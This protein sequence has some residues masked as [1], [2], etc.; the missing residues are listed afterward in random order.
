MLF[1]S[2]LLKLEQQ[3]QKESD[4]GF[5]AS[6]KNKE[7]IAKA[8]ADEGNR[9]LREA[10]EDKKAQAKIASN[11]AIKIAEEEADAKFAIYKKS[12]ND[13]SALM[14]ANL[15]SIPAKQDQNMLA[16]KFMGGDEIAVNE[17]IILSY[18]EKAQAIIAANLA[19]GK[20]EAELTA[21]IREQSE[22]AALN[23]K[24]MTETGFS[25]AQ[26]ARMT[27]VKGEIKSVNTELKGVKTTSEGI[28]KSFGA[29]MI[30]SMIIG[31]LNEASGAFQKFGEDVLKVSQSTGMAFKESSQ[32]VYIAQRTHVGVEL[33]DRSMLLMTRA[34][35][36]HTSAFRAFNVTVK[37]SNG[38]YLSAIDILKNV[39][40]KYKELGGG[41]SG[42]AM[43]HNVLGRSGQL[44]VPIL[45]QG[46]DA[47]QKMQDQTKLLGLEMSKLETQR[48]QKLKKATTDMSMAFEGLGVQVAEAA[49]P[50]QTAL[51]NGLTNLIIA[52]DKLDPKLKESIEILTI[53]A[54]SVLFVVTSYRMFSMITDTDVLA[55]LAKLIPRL[56]LMGEVIVADALA[57]TARMIPAIL[58]LVAKLNV[59]LA[60]ALANTLNELKLLGA[61]FALTGGSIVV[62][63]AAGAAFGG[64]LIVISNNA[65]H[66][67]EILSDLGSVIANV[68]NPPGRKSALQVLRKDSTDALDEIGKAAEKTYKSVTKTF[69]DM[70]KAPNLAGDIKTGEDK[71]GQYVDTSAKKPPKKNAN[72]FHDDY[73]RTQAAFDAKV[74]LLETGTKEKAGIILTNQEKLALYNEYFAT[75][76]SKHKDYWKKHEK[77]EQSYHNRRKALSEAAIKEQSELAIKEQSE[78]ATLK[79]EEEVISGK[80]TQS[81]IYADQVI[82]DKLILEEIKKHY[83]AKS[84][85]YERQ[86]KKVIES[87]KKASDYELEQIHKIAQAKAELLSDEASGKA[88]TTK[89][90]V[91]N[92]L[93]F[94]KITP[95]QAI[96]ADI[97]AEKLKGV[98]IRAAHAVALAGLNELDKNYAADLAKLERDTLNKTRANDLEILKL[99]HK[100][101]QEQYK[102]LM[103]F[104]SAIK[105]SFAPAISGMLQGTLTLQSGMKQIFGSIGKAFADMVANM[106]TKWVS[107]MFTMNTATVIW[108]MITKLA[109]GDFQLS[110]LKSSLSNIHLIGTHTAAAVAASGQAKATG[111]VA[112]VEASV[113]TA[114][115]ALA[116]A[117]TTTAASLTTVATAAPIAA[118]GLGSMG[119]AMGLLTPLATAFVPTGVAI[120]ASSTAIAAPTVT[121]ALAMGHLAVAMAAASVAWIPVI[122]AALAPIAALATGAAIAMGGTLASFAVGAESL[123]ND[124]IANVH[125]GERILTNSENSKFTN[126]IN[127]QTNSNSNQPPVV[128]NHNY[129]FIDKRGVQEFFREH[130]DDLQRASA[131][132]ARLGN[133]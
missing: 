60:L 15:S 85:E 70:F 88:N 20:S 39:A 22:A 84:V 11:E 27:A 26:I 2:A 44:L 36:A 87:T 126:F 3:Q 81:E 23:A 45:M 115:T 38:T 31:K 34:A 55:S 101:Y 18:E 72:M 129:S 80:K 105:S 13:A 43:A 69:A 73:Q 76:L 30:S 51:A 5:R 59:D 120:A 7:T 92:D 89:E 4:A 100:L 48:F 93:A 114:A 104:G 58:G 52:F 29:W 116:A 77:E 110:A 8:E 113:A 12:R 112:A 9:I 79:Y 99:S 131:S 132:N 17:K 97:D 90:N 94:G 130:R 61:G 127:N 125:K 95:Q 21:M 28:G 133:K 108:K 64:A 35:Q 128:H 123:P 102:E 83:S 6:A 46:R 40:D 37:D 62:A 106:V 96:Q 117:T 49:A 41:A 119:A 75:F 10:Y 16:S 65:F 33:L 111:K 47:I 91:S 66:L 19:G 1:R 109:H 78:L 124:M 82:A 57:M 63:I 107:S 118:T 74:S 24:M 56:I 71:Y 32:L 54:G 50:M 14:K 98:E 103:A 42:A 68:F 86:N 53:L 67:G 121:A 122:G 25:T